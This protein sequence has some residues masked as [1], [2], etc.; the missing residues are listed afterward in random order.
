MTYK[1]GETLHF[2]NEIYLLLNENP[3]ILFAQ[4]DTGRREFRGQI[5]RCGGRS[6]LFPT[7]ARNAFL[8]DLSN[9]VILD[10]TDLEEEDDL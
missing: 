9:A 6:L 5:V 1:L 2:P 4:H 3:I 7:E 8:G 10:S